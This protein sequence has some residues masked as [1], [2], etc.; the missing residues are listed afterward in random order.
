[1]RRPKEGLQQG[2][3]AVAV[4]LNGRIH[5]RIEGQAYR[6]AQVVRWCSS[7]DGVTAVQHEVHRHAVQ[8][9]R[10]RPVS[11]EEVDTSSKA[12]PESGAC[13]PQIPMLPLCIGQKR[14]VGGAVQAQAST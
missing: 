8:G 7:D 11:V 6:R 9:R 4:V 12:V 5:R 10:H 3:R 2:G 14:E 13:C 1:M